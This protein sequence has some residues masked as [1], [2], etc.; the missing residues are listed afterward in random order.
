MCGGEQVV[1][2]ISSIAAVHSTFYKPVNDFAVVLPRG[3]PAGPLLGRQI[4][5]ELCCEVPAEGKGR[6]GGGGVEEEGVIVG[7][8]EGRKGCFSEVHGG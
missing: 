2:M 8:E 4:T 1:T 6:A 5:R 7:G 3:R